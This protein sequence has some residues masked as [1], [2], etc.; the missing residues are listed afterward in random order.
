MVRENG[1]DIVIVDYMMPAPDGIEFV[2][3]CRKIPGMLDVPVVMIT[4]NT[5]KNVCRGK[6]QATAPPIF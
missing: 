3:R 6:R 1:A 5:Q 2:R 4:A